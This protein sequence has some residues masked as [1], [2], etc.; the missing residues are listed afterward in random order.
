[1]AGP[2][3][4]LASVVAF[5]ATAFAQEATYN[6]QQGAPTR[7]QP[8]HEGFLNARFWT[9]TRYRYEYV[10]QGN[11]PK[12]ARAS[13]IRN[14][15]G[16]ESGFF[17]GFRAGVE[18]EFVL[19]LGP[20]DFNNTINGRTQYPVVADVESAEVD[21]AYLESYNIPGVVL[22]GGRYLE[23]LDNL[24]YVGS[25]AWRQNDQ[26]FD[27]AKATITAL[28]GV[29]LLYAYIGNVNRI[30]SDRS[31]A[32]NINSNVHLIHAESDELSIGKLTAYTYLTDLYDLDPLS[33][34]SFGGFLKGKQGLTGGIDYHYRFEYAHQ[35]S[36]GDAP[37]DYDADYVRV[38]QGLSKA[39]FTGT[40]VYELLG[41]DNGVAAFQTPLAT[42]HVFNGFADV[43]LVIPPT[44]LQDFYAQA[45]YKVPTNIGGPFSYFGGLL[46]LAQ[47][48]EF[49]SA[50][51][52][53]DY[54]SEFD[55]YSYLP[56]RDGFYAQAKY[57]NYQA[58]D[59]FVDT[60]KVIFGL[61]YQY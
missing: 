46:L 28:P 19:E 45:K 43:F 11:K 4:L 2:C 49:R 56:L 8:P 20:N 21:Q 48:H 18:G 34:A 59:Y 24:R 13:T 51:Q 58:D 30:F 47:Y 36:Y 60:Q 27:G 39:G 52:N 31:P 14:K 57:A 1:M 3:V 5:G 55:F 50:V 9:D 44:G 35:I 10:D 37:V 41:S 16:I 40:L 54:G 23:N 17:H 53:L 29:E 26:T 33:N 61:G 7:Y 25:V 6:P 22:L 32:G 12:N 38:E 42:G 15:T